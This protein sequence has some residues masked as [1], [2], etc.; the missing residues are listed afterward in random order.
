MTNYPEVNPL[1]EAVD[2]QQLRDLFRQAPIGI[3]RTTFNGRI[4]IANQAF[5]EMLGYTS[6]K[7]FSSP[8]QQKVTDLYEDP[9]FREH[10]VEMLM[11]QHDR[12][13]HVESRWRRK[14]GTVFPCRIHVRSTVDGNGNVMHFEGF[15]EDISEQ[16][17]IES[18]LLASGDRYRSIFENTGTGT[19]IIE[20]DTTI[21]L[22]NSGFANLV[23]YS[24][25]EIEGKMKW[26]EVIAKDDDLIRMITYHKKRRNSFNN[27]PIEYEFT[28]KD[29]QGRHKEVFL[30]VDMISGTD[31]SVASLLDTTSLKL[32]KRNFRESES[33][34]TGVLEA[35]DGYIYICNSD[36]QLVHM[37]RKLEKTMGPADGNGLCYKRIFGLD[38]PCQFCIHKRVF[39]GATVKYEFQNPKDNRW[40]YAVSSP[41]YEEKNVISQ[42]Q[43]VMIDIH[44]RKLAEVALKEREVYLKKEN[45]RLRENIQDRYRFGAIIGKSKSMQQIYEQI[46]RAAATDANVIIYGESGTGKELV[47]KEIHNMSDR[48]DRIFLPVNCGAIPT[49]LMESEFFGYLKGAFTGA[50]QNKAGYFSQSDRGTLFLDELGEIGEAMQVKLLRVLEGNGYIPLGGLE[51][52]RPDV[53]IISATNSNLR[54]MLEKGTMREDF[55]YRIHII[56]LNL[57]PL[58]DRLD[59]IPL[60]V[61]HFLVKHSKGAASS[62]SGSDLDRLMRHNWPGNVRELENTIQRFINL[63]I[64]EFVET[65]GET[66]TRVRLSTPESQSLKNVS[67]R[68]AAQQFEKEHILQQLETCRWNRTRT[69]EILGIQRKTLYLKMKQFNITTQLS[70]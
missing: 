25:D 50:D 16:K 14:D 32:A 46:L 70:N 64:L 33:R 19:I 15:I 31:C 62:L 57:P 20:A 13:L 1:L 23:G 60:L 54:P 17:A 40:Y 51:P 49:E 42:K 56:P 65:G 68:E 27:A 26:P 48:K 69:A 10:I 52:L 3:L 38:S 37:N 4:L 8:S 6:F 47:A 11:Q 36:Y 2:L 29:R 35:F 45:I 66:N 21:S 28:L 39:Q 34:L 12:P 67:L 30:R 41:I 59:D 7:E 53:R 63:N 5:V 22:A 24:K 9:S 61:E 43:T 44:E 18:A 58:R 55:F